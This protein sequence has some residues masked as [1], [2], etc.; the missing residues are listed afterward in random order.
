MREPAAAVRMKFEKDGTLRNI[1]AR[2]RTEKTLNFLF[3]NARKVAPET[4]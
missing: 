2:I 3:E 1:A 4:A